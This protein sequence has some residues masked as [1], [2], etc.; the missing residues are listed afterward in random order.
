[1]MSEFELHLEKNP[2]A[3]KSAKRVT[4]RIVRR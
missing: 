2:P 4:K 1:M 3:R